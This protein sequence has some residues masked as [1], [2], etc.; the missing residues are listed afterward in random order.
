M[1]KKQLE[2]QGSRE[3]FH[4]NESRCAGHCHLSHTGQS[5]CVIP[6]GGQPQ[7]AHYLA[8]ISKNCL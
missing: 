7:L 3:F 2:A 1:K 5:L 6:A 4:E 8:N